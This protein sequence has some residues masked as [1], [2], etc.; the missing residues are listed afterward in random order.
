[1]TRAERFERDLPDLLADLVS[2]APPEDLADALSAMASVRQRPAWTF[3]LRW[4]PGRLE[5]SIAPRMSWRLVGL[6]AIVAIVLAA[7]VI[8]AL[9]AGSR[10]QLPPPFGPAANG[11]LIYD[12]DGDIFTA[13]PV[14]GATHRI[15]SGPDIDTRP[16]WSRDGTR[17][18]FERTRADARPMGQLIVAGARGDH[19]VVASTEPLL[20]LRTYGFSPDGRSVI[21]TAT[22]GFTESIVVAPSDGSGPPRVLDLGGNVVIRGDLDPG[23]AY[24]P[25]DGDEI[26]FMAQRSDDS[27]G[28]Y[29]VDLSTGDVRTIVRPRDPIYLFDPTWSPDGDRVAYGSFRSSDNCTARIHLIDADGSHDRRVD[30]RTDTQCDGLGHVWS[31]DGS[32]LVY[33]RS[34]SR[35]GDLNWA[36]VPVDGSSS[37]V[38]IPCPLGYTSCWSRWEWAPNDSMLV[39]VIAGGRVVPSFADRGALTPEADLMV[40]PRTGVATPIPW[41]TTTGLSWQRTAP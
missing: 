32:R 41:T 40:D 26:L 28:I 15:V 13:D 3:P 38:E 12:A 29:A 2:P 14:T 10:R 22:V 30:L 17:F 5:I 7:M 36:V 6:L 20:H 9:L 18:V 33:S 11:L 23:P 16:M 1:M 27:P 39:G 4:L 37:G 19:L 34:R 35:L 21:A 25:P 8:G 24:R 31:N